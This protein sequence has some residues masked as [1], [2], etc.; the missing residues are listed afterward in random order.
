MAGHH[1][2]IVRAQRQLLVDR[3]LP[4]GTSL[5]NR[6]TW[7]LHRWKAL[8]QTQY[9]VG[10]YRLDYAWPSVRI[11]LEADGPFHRSP[12]NAARDVVR[13]CYL[14]SLGWL[15]FRVDDAGGNL[16]EQLLRVVL[17]VRAEGW[18]AG[19]RAAR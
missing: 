5:E 2:T 17:C 11:A 7:L 6:V 19:K 1:S 18:Q 3:G 9:R 12:D 10:K 16:E 4:T 15:V 14:R 13:D 8:D